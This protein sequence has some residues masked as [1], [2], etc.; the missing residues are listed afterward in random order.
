[1][2]LL[3]DYDCDRSYFCKEATQKGVI[4]CLNENY[5]NVPAIV[6]PVNESRA[7]KPIVGMLLNN[8]V[9]IDLT[10]HSCLSIPTSVVPKGGRVQILK[11]GEVALQFPR[12]WKL[13]IN[14]P[15]YVNFKTGQLTWRAVGPQKAVTLSSQD[16]DG[17]CNVRIEF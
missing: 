7:S 17:F 15:L 4:V 11:R 1:M 14:Q 16:A 13:P 8:V 10:R 2:R 5:N 3:R 9:D 12:C 6:A